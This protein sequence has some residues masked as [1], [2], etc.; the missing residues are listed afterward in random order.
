MMGSMPSFWHSMQSL[1]IA[2]RACAWHIQACV[3]SLL[4]RLVKIR[5]LLP[6]TR[7][8]GCKQVDSPIDV[9]HRLVDCECE[10]VGKG[11]Y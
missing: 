11:R 10:V 2:C 1:C 5:S 8:L 6:E 9:N 4:T 7:M 3:F